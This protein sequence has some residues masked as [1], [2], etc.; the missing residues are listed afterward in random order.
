MVVVDMSLSAWDSGD[1]DFLLGDWE[2]EFT[3]GYV[4]RRVA[5]DHLDDPVLHLQLYEPY[6]VDSSG[7][8]DMPLWA[9]RALALPGPGPAVSTTWETVLRL[10]WK[11]IDKLPLATWMRF[12]GDINVRE[13]SLVR[14][15][16]KETNIDVL[17]TL[18]NRTGAVNARVL[19]SSTHASN[20]A[21]VFQLDT[22]ER[23]ARQDKRHTHFFPPEDFDR[24]VRL[25]DIQAG[26]RGAQTGEML[27]E[28][29]EL[30]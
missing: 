30:Q 12:Y 15:N 10:P 28:R 1:Q 25:K 3:V 18:P 27:M 5:S 20:T 2:Q 8:P 14:A 7:Q 11:P 24:L 26:R 23:R 16:W 22:E 6:H 21:A 19:C 9:W 17:E 13:R 29:E 4:Y